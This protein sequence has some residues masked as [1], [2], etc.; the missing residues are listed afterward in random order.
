M[1]NGNFISIVSAFGLAVAFVLTPILADAGSGRRGN[2]YD[3]NRAQIQREVSRSLN[4]KMERVHYYDSRGR[5]YR[6][7][8]VYTDLDTGR[9]RW[10]HD[11]P[12]SRW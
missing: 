6:E 9:R 8:R 7:D 11:V 2:R 1:K 12:K 10:E 5:K 3:W 4:E